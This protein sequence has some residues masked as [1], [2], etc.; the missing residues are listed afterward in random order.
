VSILSAA[1]TTARIVALPGLATGI[2]TAWYNSS[3]TS[4]GSIQSP[5]VVL[6]SSARPINAPPEKSWSKRSRCEVQALSTPVGSVINTHSAP[7][8]SRSSSA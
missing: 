8:C 1:E 3:P 5:A 4:L 2:A 7:I 6:P